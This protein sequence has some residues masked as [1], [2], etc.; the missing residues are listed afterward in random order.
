M[1]ETILFKDPKEKPNPKNLEKALGKKY[2]LFLD[3]TSKLNEQNLSI[4]WNYYNDGKSWLGKLLVKK[5]NLCWISIWNTGLK[6]TVF[7]TEKTIDDFYGLNINEE[8]KTSAQTVKRVGKF[9][10]VIMLIKS[11]KMVN[12]CLKV[13]EYKKALK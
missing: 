8:I 1:E 3:F 10:P 9:I 7:F 5:K 4:E 12:D 13:L 6:V 2:A 11:K